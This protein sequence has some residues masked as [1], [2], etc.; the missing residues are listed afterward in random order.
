[1]RR[2]SKPNATFE[3]LLDDAPQFEALGEGESA[4]SVEALSEGMHALRA[5]ATANDHPTLG[6][7]TDS[8]PA[9]YSF[10]EAA[11]TRGNPSLRR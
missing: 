4:Y 3:V 7:A 8:T 11:T 2:L 6:N 10:A 9:V 5:R 1:M